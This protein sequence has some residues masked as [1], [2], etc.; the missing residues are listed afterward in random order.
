MEPETAKLGSSLLVDSVKELAKKALIEVPERY[1]HPNIDP[2]ILVNTDSLLPQL[3][4]IELH[5]LLS[6][7]L[8]ELEKLDFACKDWGFFQ[9]S[10]YIF[11]LLL[12]HFYMYVFFSHCFDPPTELHNKILLRIRG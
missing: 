5:K 3:P 1:V 9:V 8:K 11:S 12:F 2:P 7:D 4:I 6:E 10:I